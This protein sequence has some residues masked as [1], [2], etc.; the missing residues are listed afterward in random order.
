MNNNFIQWVLYRHMLIYYLQIRLLLILKG[1]Y[2]M[3]GRFLYNNTVKPVKFWLAIAF[4][5][6]QIFIF[7][8]FLPIALLI[9]LSNNR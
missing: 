5:P 2:N 3:I 7:I 1:G 9:K 4:L 8:A 6:V